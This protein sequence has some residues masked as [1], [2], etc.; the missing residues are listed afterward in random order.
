MGG[1]VTQRAL[2]VFH[3]VFFDILAIFYRC[4]QRRHVWAASTH[5]FLGAWR[6][7]FVPILRASTAIGRVFNSLKVP[8][9]VDT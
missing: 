4:R 7:T 1:V 2:G 8:F 5:T 3:A 9:T 6:T